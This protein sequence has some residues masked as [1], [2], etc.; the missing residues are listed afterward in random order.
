MGWTFVGVSDGNLLFKQFLEAY[1]LR[2]DGRLVLLVL[3]GS[4]GLVFRGVAS[5]SCLPTHLN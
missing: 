2:Y 3:F 5:E 4:L 1:G